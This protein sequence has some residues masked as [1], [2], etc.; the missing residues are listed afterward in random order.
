[1]IYFSKPLPDPAEILVIAMCFY[2]GHLTR[3][4]RGDSGENFLSIFTKL[5]SSYFYNKYTHANLHRTIWN[6]GVAFLDPV[7]KPRDDGNENEKNFY[8]YKFGI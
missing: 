3:I 2:T 6:F 5:K 4:L 7:V 8:I 1:M